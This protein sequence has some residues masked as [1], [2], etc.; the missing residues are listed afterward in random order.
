MDEDVVPRGRN[1][2]NGPMKTP[3]TR[4]PANGP[5]ERG[6]GEKRTAKTETSTRSSVERIRHLACGLSLFFEEAELGAIRR[7]TM[8]RSDSYVTSSPHPKSGAD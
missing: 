7:T 3:R 1:V 5:D 4:S 6:T 2:F 8:D